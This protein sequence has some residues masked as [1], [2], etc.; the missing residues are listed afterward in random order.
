MKLIIGLGN[1]GA[2]YRYSRHN[3]GFKCIDHM[4]RTWGIEVGERRPKVV[5]GQGRVAHPDVQDSLAVVLA[6]PRTYMNNSG[7]GIAYLLTRFAA[8]PQDMVIIYDEMDL[9]PGRIRVR[10]EGGAGGHNGVRSII[11]TLSTQD[12]PRVRVGIGK[13]PPGLDGMSY[14]LS[15]FPPEEKRVIEEA[16]TTVADVVA[17]LVQEGIEKAMNRYN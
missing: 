2:R 16:V 14:V 8:T 17:C 11:S 13:P 10:P 5:L 1:P 4:A 12:F 7:E 6:K 9:A 15:T 3:V